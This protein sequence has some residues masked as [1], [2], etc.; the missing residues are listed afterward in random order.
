MGMDIGWAVEQMR[1]GKRVTRES[2]DGVWCALMVPGDWK[3]YTGHICVRT[4][5]GKMITWH[6]T[7]FDLL[8]D[9]WRL[10]DG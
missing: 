8:A 1:E 4:A 7:S 2:W 5:K 3:T 6:P 9:D 10:T